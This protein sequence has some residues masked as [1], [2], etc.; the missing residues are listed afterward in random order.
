ML[1]YNVEEWEAQAVSNILSMSYL[2]L[3]CVSKGVVSTAECGGAHFGKRG[4]SSDLI[5]QSV[6]SSCSIGVQNQNKDPKISTICTLKISHISSAN[7]YTGSTLQE[8]LAEG[9]VWNFRFKPGIRPLW[10]AKCGLLMHLSQ[11]NSLCIKF[12]LYILCRKNGPYYLG[13]VMW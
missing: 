3:F 8:T 7:R 11:F 5:F 4:G 12:T 1:L 13:V 9:G 2:C 6:V 10:Y